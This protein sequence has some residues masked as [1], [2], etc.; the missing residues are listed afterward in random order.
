M[1]KAW[2]GEGEGLPGAEQLGRWREEI[3][4]LRACAW[5]GEGVAE[6]L[7]VMFGEGLLAYTQAEAVRRW[8]RSAQVI[9]HMLSS[10]QAAALVQSFVGA[11]ARILQV[12]EWLEEGVEAQQLSL[13]Q[14]GWLLRLLAVVVQ[15]EDAATIA[16]ALFRGDDSCNGYDGYGG[17]GGQSGHVAG[18][19][20]LSDVLR[21]LVGVPKSFNQF[22]A[23]SPGKAGASGDRSVSSPLGRDGGL[24]HGPLSPA[25]PS[26]AP[27]GKS[28]GRVAEWEGGILQKIVREVLVLDAVEG[29]EGWRADNESVHPALA[30]DDLSTCFTMTDA[31]SGQ[32]ICYDA[33]ALVARLTARL[34]HPEAATLA[35]QEEATACVD[36][37]VLSPFDGHNTLQRLQSAR[38][39]VLCGLRDV[40]A[41]LQG[42]LAAG[43]QHQAWVAFDFVYDLVNSHLVPLFP[44]DKAGAH[45]EVGVHT[46][47]LVRQGLDR[48]ATVGVRLPPPPGSAVRWLLD[49][50]GSVAEEDRLRGARAR[51]H[52]VKLLDSLL[53]LLCAWAPEG[54]GQGRSPVKGLQ[55]VAG[56]GPGGARPQVELASALIRREVYASVLALL[57]LI[58]GEA[59]LSVPAPPAVDVEKVVGA[60]R[61]ELLSVVMFDAL[62]QARVA[63]SDE[64][65]DVRLFA[66]RV[67]LHVLPLAA[68]GA[69]P[70]RRSATAVR[71]PNAASLAASSAASGF[72]AGWPAAQERGGLSLA[73]VLDQYPLSVYLAADFA[74]NTALG[75]VVRAAIGMGGGGDSAVVDEFVAKVAI[76]KALASHPVGLATLQHVS[77]VYTICTS[78]LLS[79]TLSAET[80][81]HALLCPRAGAA[82]D[83]MTA[84]ERRRAHQVVLATMEALV[85][86][87]MG[88][89]YVCQRG[90][91]VY[92]CVNRSVPYV[93]VYL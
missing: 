91:R 66:L 74:G 80:R 81:A 65:A 25:S 18:Q 35:Q 38:Q 76:I 28:L 55:Q 7:V 61:G 77:L 4:Q 75:D 88:S 37:R 24:S 13:Q 52:L 36:A 84:A 10:E 59:G 49:L 54:R 70:L 79:A 29:R 16:S 93:F 45:L 90:L 22:G 73:G 48:L 68:D 56:E 21:A 40:V 89:G 67:L 19:A 32:S 31:W 44:T 82:D 78:T 72:K 85:S 47:V 11:R 33:D 17:A 34:A 53:S 26:G 58:S 63:S 23:A 1:A 71:A 39:H 6:E 92:V 46:S 9:P 83:A 2:G 15:Q 64:A 42:P 30:P 57:G 5:L 41:V 3:R 12:E 69:R 43:G 86:V 27:G 14:T 8:Q 51:K 50:P 87:A 60:R 62:A 20:L